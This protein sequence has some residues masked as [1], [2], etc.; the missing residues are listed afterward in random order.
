MS[1]RY[2]VNRQIRWGEEVP[3]AVEI[4]YGGMFP[5]EDVFNYAGPDQCVPFFPGE[6]QEYQTIDDARAAALSVLAAW[7]A[8]LR[9]PIVLVFAGQ[10]VSEEDR[11][12]FESQASREPRCLECDSVVPAYQTHARRYCSSRCQ[13]HEDCAEDHEEAL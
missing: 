11:T 1:S 5:R 10:E 3:H 13:A 7:R 2:Y 12:W 8:A 9:E 6:G 4:A